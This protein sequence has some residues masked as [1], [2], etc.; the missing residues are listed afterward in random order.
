MHRATRE[1]DLSRPPATPEGA[2]SAR[3]KRFGLSAKTL[4]TTV[5]PVFMM[6]IFVV[7]LLTLQRANTL[8]TLGR[9]LADSVVRILATTLDVQDL[10]LVNTQLQAAVSS[11][12]VAF[13]DVRPSGAVLR[14]FTSKDPETDWLLLRQYDAF[15]K[16]TPNSRHFQFQDSRAS[17]YRRILEQVR[18]TGARADVQEHLQATLSRLTTL[19]GRA[20]DLQVIEVEVYASPTG[21]RR[22]RAR[23]QAKPEGQK[24][25]DLGIGVVSKPV[26]DLLDLQLRRV[27]LLSAL[28]LLG[29]LALAVWFGRRLVRPVLALTEAVNR[30][31]LGVMDAPIP[32]QDGDELADLAESVERLRVSLKLALS[33]LRPRGPQ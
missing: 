20:E 11:E 6:G 33:R 24:L 15:L 16:R 31:S 17:E 3:R 19:E 12:N 1:R 21:G 29:T 26:R 23:D 7:L 25:F 5:L 8:E 13:V 18:S 30:I 27:L 28:A 32:R 2:P 10:T 4:L 14:F 9:S 22:V